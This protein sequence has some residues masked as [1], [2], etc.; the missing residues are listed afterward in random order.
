[1]EQ[2]NNDDKFEGDSVI[3]GSTINESQLLADFYSPNHTIIHI[4]ETL[5]G[6]N[7]LIFEDSGSFI[8]TIPETQNTPTVSTLSHSMDSMFLHTNQEASLASDSFLNDSASLLPITNGIIDE[9]PLLV[10]SSMVPPEDVNAIHTRTV[11]DLL[12][13]N[14]RIKCLLKEIDELKLDKTINTAHLSL[15]QPEM[16]KRTDIQPISNTRPDQNEMLLFRAS[17]RHQILSNFFLDKLIIK[18]VTFNSAEQA[19]QF[20][21][22]QFHGRQDLAIKILRTRSPFQIKKIANGI[23]QCQAWHEV[24]TEIM[25][26]I[27]NEKAKQCSTFRKS[28]VKTGSKKLIH[29][30]ESDSFWG[31]GD[32]FL[33]QNVQGM[34]LEELRM[35]IQLELPKPLQTEQKGK[36][37]STETVDDNS[38]S[39]RQKIAPQSAVP[40][41]PFAMAHV[42]ATINNTRPKIVIIGNSNARGI[43]E[44]LNERGLD[45]CGYVFP[46]GTISHITSRIRNMTSSQ[47]PDFVMLMAGD[48]EAAD[49]L[50]AAT[51][52]A[53][54]EH[55]I[56]GAKRA[57][58]FSRIIISGLAQTGG[59]TQRETLRDVNRH[60]E[61]LG[62]DERLLEFICNEQAKLRDHIHLSRNSVN[63]LSF[64]VSLYVKKVFL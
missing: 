60:L 17:G 28:L 13:A 50:A 38:T 62:N 6:D 22:A 3:I 56:D 11:T 27:L 63:K 26:E 42:S 12:H 23:I 18:G 44:G 57:F 7:S 49:G 20:K 29:N 41:S 21:K 58:P 14:E 5:M 15:D 39:Q 36:Q 53:R 33:G 46:G 61:I 54:Y 34:L 8:Q 25:Q 4:P 24:K 55:L 43:S 2:L 10:S 48:I 9:F 35:S 64:N 30:V 31:C 51:I 19:Y 45:A 52:C 1:M 37:K 47:S 16:K 40:P 59:H 32:N